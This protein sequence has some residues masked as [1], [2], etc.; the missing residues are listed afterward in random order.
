MNIHWIKLS[1]S[2]SQTQSIVQYLL[3]WYTQYFH[4]TV[5]SRCCFPSVIRY[6]SRQLY[7]EQQSMRPKQRWTHDMKQPSTVCLSHRQWQKKVHHLKAKNESDATILKPSLV[8]DK[9][10]TVTK[11]S[12]RCYGVRLCHWSWALCSFKNFSSKNRYWDNL[13]R[14]PLHD[15]RKK[16]ETEWW[17]E[18]WNE[19]QMR[20]RQLRDVHFLILIISVIF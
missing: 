3:I 14:S 8:H 20:D 19:E 16:R 10:Q 9:K 7:I 17:N 1:L 5:W 4:S 12:S 13:P 6:N 2:D 18:T 11:D 15:R